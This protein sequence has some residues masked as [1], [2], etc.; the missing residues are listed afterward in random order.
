MI[1]YYN[2]ISRHETLIKLLFSCGLKCAFVLPSVVLMYFNPSLVL[3]K[4]L[5]FCSLNSKVF[6]PF[7]RNS[8]PST[9]SCALC[10][11][12]P[13]PPHTHNMTGKVEHGH[14]VEKIHRTQRTKGLYPVMMILLWE[15]CGSDESKVYLW[16]SFIT[17]LNTSPGF[18][19]DTFM[20]T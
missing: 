16:Q 8:I 10:V 9:A 7:K 15:F 2:I 4:H 19:R 1:L 14:S 20:S 12:T 5:K 3:C 11:L 13:L 18:K 6:D 17:K